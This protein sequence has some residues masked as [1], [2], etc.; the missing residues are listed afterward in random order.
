MNDLSL[1]WK[2]VSRGLPRVKKSSD[3]APTLEELRKMMEYPNRRIKSIFC[4]MTSDGFRLGARDY[5]RWKHMIPI[6]N[7]KEEIT[8][9]RVVIYAERVATKM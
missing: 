4:S 3:R 9:A 2:K 1:N 8:A 6:S 7:N 5:L